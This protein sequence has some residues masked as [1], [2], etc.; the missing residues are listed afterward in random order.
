MTGNLC[1][2]CMSDTAG[3]TECPNCGFSSAEP[4]MNHAL[5]YRTMLQNRYLVG[6]A[7]QSNGEGITYIGYDSVLNS[8]I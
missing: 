7:K 6:R 5:P 4:Q 2:N 1:M 8:S 3:K